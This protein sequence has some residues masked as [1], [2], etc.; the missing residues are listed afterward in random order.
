MQRTIFIGHTDMQWRNVCERLFAASGFEVASG[1][2]GLTC[3]ARLRTWMPDVL[4]VELELP[5]GGGDGVVA[6]LREQSD[7]WTMPVL[8]ILGHASPKTLSRQTGVPASC[9]LQE[10][11]AP[12]A[13][14]DAVCD[15]L[16]PLRW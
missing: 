10:P 15:A 14:L 4:V 13:L 8:F 16:S 6:W 12:T 5:W 7:P 3:I 9:C 11:L 2:D 1:Q